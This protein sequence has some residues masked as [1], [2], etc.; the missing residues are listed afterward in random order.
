M[1]FVSKK[2][3]KNRRAKTFTITLED[4][5][6]W[7]ARRMSANDEAAY[8]QAFATTEN[9][10][11]RLMFLAAFVLRDPED[12]DK[13][14]FDLE[15]EEEMKE[16]GK[17]SPD[18]LLEISEQYSAHVNPPRSNEELEEHAKN[19]ETTGPDS[20]SLTSVENSEET[21][22]TQISSSTDSTPSR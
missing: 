21:T 15:N 12:P 6:E 4:G 18:D 10:G 20:S 17:W 14:L 16:L 7:L 19:S 9:W 3:A 1:A 8:S 13:P 11:L 2:D 22:S 5:S